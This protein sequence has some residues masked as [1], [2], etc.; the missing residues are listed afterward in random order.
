MHAD[1]EVQ[2]PWSE[3]RRG[4]WEAVCVCGVPYHHD[5]ITDDPYAA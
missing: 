5:P 4:V 2:I 3:I 1:P